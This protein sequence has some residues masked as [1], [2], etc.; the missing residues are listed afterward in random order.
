MADEVNFETHFLSI[1]D[2]RSVLHGVQRHIVNMAYRLW[3]DTVELQSQS[4]YKEYMAQLRAAAGASGVSVGV[5]ASPS[6]ER[7]VTTTQAAQDDDS[8]EDEE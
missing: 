5:G 3:R 4:R 8:W 6:Q 1:D 2:A 7:L